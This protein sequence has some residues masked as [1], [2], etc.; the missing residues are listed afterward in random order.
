VSVVRAELWRRL[1]ISDGLELSFDATR[2]NPS[3][4]DL[5]RLR[6]TIAGVFRD[7]PDGRTV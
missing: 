5:M 4:E 3:V 1:R 2:F 7:E 6:D